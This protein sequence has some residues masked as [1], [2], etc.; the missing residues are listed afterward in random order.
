MR[1]V[2]KGDSS[3]TELAQ[4]KQRIDELEDENASLRLWQ[5]RRNFVDSA[6]SKYN[7][8]QLK[9]LARENE[10]AVGGSKIELLIR[11]VE[12]EAINLP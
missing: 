2:F 8:E 10:V 1:V 6:L 5:E 9:K 12:A 7:V 3:T 11:L 4:L